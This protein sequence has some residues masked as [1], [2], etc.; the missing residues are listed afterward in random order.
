MMNKKSVGVSPLFPTQ[1]TGVVAV[2]LGGQRVSLIPKGKPPNPPSPRRLVLEA[3]P[4]NRALLFRHC[5]CCF[6]V[7][8]ACCSFL[9]NQVEEL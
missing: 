2:G 1:L 3:R 4:K 5:C 9:G 8:L 7:S 6:F